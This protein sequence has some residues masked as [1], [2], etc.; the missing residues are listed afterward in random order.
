M[1][2][3]PEAGMLAYVRAGRD[4]GRAVLIREVLDENFVMIVD[5]DMRKLDSPKK[6]K[7]KHLKLSPKLD[8]ALQKAFL[9][10]IIVDD[11][12]VRRAIAGLTGT[13]E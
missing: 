10:G 13:D 3:I 2:I 6:K 5:G 8:S 1:K 7:L 4:E 9:E 12:D 11:A